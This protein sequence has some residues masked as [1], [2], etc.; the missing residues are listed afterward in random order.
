MFLFP[1]FFLLK[2]SKTTFNQAGMNGDA[3]SIK[4]P[5][6]CSKKFVAALRG[7]FLTRG[8]ILRLRFFVLKRFWGASIEKVSPLRLI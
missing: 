1:E 3:F 7:K 2:P 4:A 6:E 5:E 8:N